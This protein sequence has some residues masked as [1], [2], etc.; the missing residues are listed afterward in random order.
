MISDV[1]S[2]AI[3]EVRDY[4]E[5]MPDVYAPV[6]PEIEA[7]ARQTDLLIWTL[8]HLPVAGQEPIGPT[9]Q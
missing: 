9:R 7:W 4:L 1:L 3:A 2:D 6:R 5:T 8:D